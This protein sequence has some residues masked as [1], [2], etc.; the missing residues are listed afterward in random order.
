ML[1]CH[2]LRFSLAVAAVLVLAGPISVAVADDGAPPTVPDDVA[3]AA[4]YRESLPTASGKVPS[5]TV[6]GRPR[7]LTPRVQTAISA[8]GGR[9]KKLLTAVGS[10]SAGRVADKRPQ[11]NADGAGVSQPNAVK[12]ALATLGLS[13]DMIALL[14]VLVGGTLLTALV[15]RHQRPVRTSA[16]TERPPR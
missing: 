5:A 11:P 14:I 15:A 12:A 9:D 4:Q 6:Q 8:R 10:S 13:P 2:R 1:Y 3:A 16:R 7:T